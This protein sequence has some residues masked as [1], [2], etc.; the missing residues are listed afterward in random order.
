MDK[1][2]S[3]NCKITVKSEGNGW[4][5]EVKSGGFITF[6]KDGFS[7][8]YEID[9]DRAEFKYSDGKCRQKRTGDQNIFIEFEESARTFLEIS[10]SGLSGKYEIYTERLKY[11]TGKGGVKV[12]L[13]Y[14]S[15][16]EER[17]FLTF[18]AVLT[19]RRK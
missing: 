15:G 11:I 18:C 1:N 5:Q 14:N 9:G 8:V 6:F 16:K 19:D 10:S 3:L 12:S 17:I 4:R 13:Y 7:A 2:N